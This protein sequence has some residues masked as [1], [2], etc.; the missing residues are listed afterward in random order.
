[1]KELLDKL[2]VTWK[3][4]FL[5]VVLIVVGVFTFMNTAEAAEDYFYT[6]F[7]IGKVDGDWED[8]GKFTTG[9]NFGYARR[10]HSNIWMM[11]EFEHRSQLM[12]GAP[13]NDLP[14]S[15]TDAVLVRLEWRFGE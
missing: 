8:S 6:G 12:A 3:E 13:F 1:M 15:H 5:V 14:E 2:G 7:H 11:G 4:F 10:M 9:L